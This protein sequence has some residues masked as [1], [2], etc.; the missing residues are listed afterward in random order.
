MLKDGDRAVYGGIMEDLKLI[1]CWDECIE[2]SRFSQ[3][4][5]EVDDFNEKNRCDI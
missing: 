1:E 5:Q 4:R 3:Q 2:K